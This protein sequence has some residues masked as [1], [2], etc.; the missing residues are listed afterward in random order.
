MLSPD[1]VM[2]GQFPLACCF[3]CYGRYNNR[4]TMFIADIVLY[5]NNRATPL[6]F[7]A[8]ATTKIGILHLAALICSFHLFMTSLIFSGDMYRLC[9]EIPFVPDTPNLCG[10]PSNS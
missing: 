4:R 8:N 6:L 7:G 2:G 10:H 9:R 5:D 3:S 1:F